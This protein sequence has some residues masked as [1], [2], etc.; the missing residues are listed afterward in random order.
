MTGLLIMM[1]ALVAGWPRTTARRRLRR[2]CAPRRLRPARRPDLLRWIPSAVGLSVA[3]V[4]EGW[5]GVVAGTAVGIVLHRLP[6]H[7]ES[8]A[9]RRQRLTA[10]AALPFGLDLLAASL[11]AG[12]PPAAAFRAVGAALGGPL[13]GRLCR[14]AEALTLGA[15][16][17]EAWA[18]LDGVPGA[19]RLV[20]VAVRS[21]QSGAAL[22]GAL[23]RLADELRAARATACEAAARR[24][25]VLVVLP[26]GLCFLPAF[27]LAGLVPIVLSV[28]GEVIH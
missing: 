5:S 19:G 24:S 16:P 21:S 27:V 15:P 1:A 14:V 13:G 18:H 9:T 12:A 3:L 8:R 20:L 2:I 23:S 28:L 6:R 4:V 11:R 17:A 25:G 22:A 26:L 7:L 10:A